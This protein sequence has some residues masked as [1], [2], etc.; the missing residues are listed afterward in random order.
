TSWGILL[1]KRL[2]ADISQ[3]PEVVV[4][5]GKTAQIPCN[6]GISTYNSLYWYM[7]KQ[8]VAP[9]YIISGYSAPVRNG[10]FNM[11]I[12]KGNTSTELS[13]GEVEIADAGVYYLNIL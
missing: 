10:R 4:S 13:I 6:H 5:A 3:P 7:Q 9:D 11:T 2:N 8:D 1:L 12:D